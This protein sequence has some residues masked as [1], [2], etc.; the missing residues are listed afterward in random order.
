MLIIYER[1]LVDDTS[2]KKTLKARKSEFGIK[3]DS[4]RN[5]SDPFI[6]SELME[7]LAFTL[8]DIFC[9]GSEQLCIFSECHGVGS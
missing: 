6:T 4:S 7:Q 5:G 2:S 3:W 1:V 9:E 8:R